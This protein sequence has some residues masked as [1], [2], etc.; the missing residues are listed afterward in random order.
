MEQRGSS[1]DAWILTLGADDPRSPQE[2]WDGPGSPGA[3]RPGAPGT[4]A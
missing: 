3:V 4:A 1:V 2:P